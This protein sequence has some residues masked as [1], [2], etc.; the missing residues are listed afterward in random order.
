MFL[1]ITFVL[2]YLKNRSKLFGVMTMCLLA[3][4]FM[5]YCVVLLV[6]GFGHVMVHNYQGMCVLSGVLIQV[7]TLI[8]CLQNAYRSRHNE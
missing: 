5:F 8:F 7:K 1:G 4:L 2:V 6:K 3:M